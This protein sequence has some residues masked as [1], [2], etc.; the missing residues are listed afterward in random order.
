MTG[1]YNCP[2]IL[3][4]GKIYNKGCYH[5]VGCKVYYNSPKQVLY[6]DCNK[7][8]SSDYNACKKYLG[9]Y[10]SREFY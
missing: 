5:P 3:R 8:T 10:R 7:P 9:K 6:I 2:Y 4:T 1:F